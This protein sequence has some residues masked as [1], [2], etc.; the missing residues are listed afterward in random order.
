MRCTNQQTRWFVIWL[1]VFAALIGT[2]HTAGTIAT[3]A[4]E[5][6]GRIDHRMIL[7]NKRTSRV[8]R[9]ETRDPDAMAK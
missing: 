4:N 1:L 3:N 9:R 7:G 2:A 8:A 6:R 5:Q